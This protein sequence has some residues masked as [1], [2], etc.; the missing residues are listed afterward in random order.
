[1]EAQRAFLMQ[2]WVLWMSCPQFL[3]IS[4][5]QELNGPFQ[6]LDRKGFSIE[7]IEKRQQCF[8]ARKRALLRRAPCRLRQDMT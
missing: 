2:S 3:W 4:P 7:C 5:P 6:V 8:D 1:M